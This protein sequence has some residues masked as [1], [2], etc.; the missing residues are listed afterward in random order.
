MET[1]IK[2]WKEK[3]ITRA[4]FR[5]SCGGDSMNDWGLEYFDEN[6]NAMDFD[7]EYEKEL[8]DMVLDKVEF[9]EASDGYYQ[10]EAG[11]VYI[12]LNDDEDGFE[13]VK[14]AESEFSE[15]MTSEIT[16]E[17]TDA[18]RDYLIDKVSTIEGG[19]SAYAEVNYS[20][21]F[22]RT[23][24]LKKLE[25]ELI[26]KIDD[27]ADNFC[28]DIEEEVQDYYSYTLSNHE[29]DGNIKIEGNMLSIFVDNNYYSY[30]Q[31]ND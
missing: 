29:T 23:E 17:I 31:S 28:P 8:E 20:K 4:E 24:E 14:E 22:I 13:F 1:M 18:E 19:D 21:N 25:E 3:G 26:H 10:G 9:Y 16:I 30:V 12:T 15:S 6:D 5:F 11:T 27:A 2:E 7:F